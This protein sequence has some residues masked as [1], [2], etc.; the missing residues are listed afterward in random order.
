MAGSG[1]PRC[2][3]GFSGQAVLKVYP[4]NPLI[5]KDMAL[6]REM[7]GGGV[8]GAADQKMDFTRAVRGFIGQRGSAMGAEGA[9][10]L[11]RALVPAGRLTLE[12]EVLV[13]V[14]GIGRD[15]RSGR[16]PA[17]LAMAIAAE[18]RRT[19]R[20]IFHPS[21]KTMPGGFQ[22]H[23]RSVAP[24]ERW[25]KSAHLFFSSPFRGR[26]GWGHCSRDAQDPAPGLPKTIVAN[27]WR[28]ILG[29]QAAVPPS[30]PS[31]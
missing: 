16:P 15:R 12:P 1:S 22:A 18:L 21:A 20:P 27:T 14:S 25:R 26:V 17:A 10:H 19:R 28:W 29:A 4:G 2:G 23:A 30:R 5:F 3:C 11:G 31:P 7:V 24:A 6:R 13:E 9:G 8:G